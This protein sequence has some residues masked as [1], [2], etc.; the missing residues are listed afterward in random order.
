[1]ILLYSEIRLGRAKTNLKLLALTPPSGVADVSRENQLYGKAKYAYQR[2]IAQSL[3][4]A[5]QLQAVLRGIEP[6]TNAPAVM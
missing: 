5:R 4:R 1:M 2:S 6:N 3:A